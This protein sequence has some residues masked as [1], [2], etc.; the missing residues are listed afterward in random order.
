MRPGPWSCGRRGSEGERG[1]GCEGRAGGAHQAVALAEDE[2]ERGRDVGVTQQ[3]AERL[4]PGLLPLQ[5]PPLRRRRL[6]P[7]MPALGLAWQR[8]AGQR[9]HDLAVDERLRRLGLGELIEAG[10]RELVLQRPVELRDLRCGQRALDLDPAQRVEEVQRVLR[11]A[12]SVHP[13]AVAGPQ[14]RTAVGCCTRP[15]AAPAGPTRTP[16]PENPENPKTPHL[17]KCWSA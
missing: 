2:V 8:R 6:L 7:R 17:S 3:L 11:Q 16:P 15:P 14:G 10:L 12:R 13:L 4:A 5:H 9:R 1:V